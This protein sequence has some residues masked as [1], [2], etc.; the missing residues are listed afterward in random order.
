METETFHV[1]FNGQFNRIEDAQKLIPAVHPDGYVTIVLP[2][3]LTLS[4]RLDIV[5]G[6]FGRGWDYVW[7]ADDEYFSPE[8]YPRGELARIEFTVK[9]NG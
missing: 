4:S 1:V 3:G 6:F 5:R 9:V 2:A 8:H 7:R